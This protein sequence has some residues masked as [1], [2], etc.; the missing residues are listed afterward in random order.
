MKLREVEEKLTEAGVEKVKL[1]GF[2]VDGVRRGKYVSME[3]FLRA[4]EKGLGF[5][6][7]IFGWDSSDLLY[8]RSVVTGWHTGYPDTLARIDLSTMRVV[9]WE[10]RTASFLLDFFADPETPH[11]A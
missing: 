11:P 2:D 4:A 1:G 10:P 6:N 3:K 5:C 7:V 8:D 9:P